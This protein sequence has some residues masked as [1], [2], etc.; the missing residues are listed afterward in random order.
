MTLFH[1]ILGRLL[2]PCSGRIRWTGRCSLVRIAI[3]AVMGPPS[4]GP[5]GHRWLPLWPATGMVSGVW[6]ACDGAGRRRRMCM[7]SRPRSRWRPGPWPRAMHGGA[8]PG[9]CIVRRIQPVAGWSRWRG[10]V[11]RSCGIYGGTCPSPQASWRRC[12][13]LA[14]PRSPLAMTKWVCEASGDA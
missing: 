10:M 2:Q 1:R 12:G 14:I 4:S 7:P 5:A 6:T 11:A 13:G 9:W 8:P 3:V